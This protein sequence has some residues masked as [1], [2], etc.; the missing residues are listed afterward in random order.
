[1]AGGGVKPGPNYGETNELGH[2]Q[3]AEM[4]LYSPH[5][6]FSYRAPLNKGLGSMESDERAS[7]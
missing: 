2:T 5:G 7:S 1:M 6:F 3:L 4:I